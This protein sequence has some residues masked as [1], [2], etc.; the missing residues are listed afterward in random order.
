MELW[1]QGKVKLVGD[2]ESLIEVTT[3]N[4]GSY[5]FEL[6]PLTTYEILVF[7]GYLNNKVRDYRW[8]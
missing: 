1:L 8:N 4:T 2:D 5:N 7:K 6:N 3:D